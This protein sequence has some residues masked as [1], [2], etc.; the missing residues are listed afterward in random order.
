[1]SSDRSGLQDDRLEIPA[2]KMLVVG[3]A[4]FIRN[5][6][7]AGPGGQVANLDFA[8]SGLNW[9]LDRHRL[10]GVVP[11]T[12]VEFTLTLGPEQLGAIA[13]YT[14]IV[15]PAAVALL[16]LLVWWRRRA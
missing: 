13:L 2:A 14:M 1:M 5:D 3:N 16:G 8:L 6:F 11:K 12:P 4:G 10:T 9:L 7:L 15:I